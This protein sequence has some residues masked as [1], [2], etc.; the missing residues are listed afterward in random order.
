MYL[1]G[2]SVRRVE[3]IAEALWGTRV[4][5]STVS[6]LNQK[7]YGHIEQWRNRS[8]YQSHPYVYVD[9]IVLKRSWRGKVR[10]LSVLVA[11]GVQEDGFR[12][13]VS[14]GA[15]EYKAGWL[16]FVRHLK[17]RGLRGVQLFI[18]DACTGL[19]EALTEVYPAAKWQGC[20]VHL[21]LHLGALHES[22]RDR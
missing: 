4:S 15:R 2:V 13:M 14:G 6:K 16:G 20:I 17:E 1:P 9:G 7:I 22:P 19:V 8:I 12:K 21:C 18:S 5:P 10:N 11:I 3:D